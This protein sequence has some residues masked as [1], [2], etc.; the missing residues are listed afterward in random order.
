MSRGSHAAHAR[1]SGGSQSRPGP[2]TRA[3]GGVAGGVSGGFP[4]KR[5]A[6]AS[7]G[8]NRMPAGSQAHP[9]SRLTVIGAIRSELTKALSLRSTMILMALNALLLPGG[10]AILA[11][12]YRFMS[13]VDPRTG[14]MM[15]HPE[16]LPASLM[17][18]AVG[19][20]V[21]TC[22]IVVAIFGVM[23]IT[24]EYVTSS[25]QSTL[26][27]NPRRVLFLNAK[28]LVTAVL[29]FLS[30]LAGLMLSWLAVHLML[31]DIGVKALAE[32]ERVLP[33]M[34][35]LGGSAVLTL[36]AV[37]AVGCGGVCRS[38]VGGIFSMIGILMIAPSILSL[39]SFGGDRFRWVQSISRC[40]PDRAVRNF[41]TG[42]V[43]AGL[44]GGNVSMSAGGSAVSG[45]SAASAASAASD[46]V[47]DPTWWQSGLILLAWVV[48]I[49]AIGTLVVKRS[50]IK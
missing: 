18:S 45:A 30:S 29:T 32:S 15:A 11:W 47:F 27:A 50:D 22:M 42:G 14:K 16:P 2:G 43:N 37:M 4:G 31:A 40:L 1:R 36:T 44:E 9:Q 5:G 25:V 28:T 24:T 6:T 23:A 20:F 49:Y 41:L 33:W 3:S 10:A 19:G 21:S 12:A 26:V 34:T 17:W 39:A 13:T 48:V 46:G 7:H 35:L 38:T 8:P